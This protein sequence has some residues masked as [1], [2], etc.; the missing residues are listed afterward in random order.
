MLQL[1][2]GD[3]RLFNVGDYISGMESPMAVSWLLCVAVF[4]RPAYIILAVIYI[5][6]CVNTRLHKLCVRWPLLEAG[7]QA[8]NIKGK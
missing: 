6:A 2:R 4:W 1:K 5:Y 3:V 7:R 8:G